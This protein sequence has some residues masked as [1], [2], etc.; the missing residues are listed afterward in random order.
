[1]KQP[2][3][4]PGR[5]V[6]SSEVSLPPFAV[7][8]SSTAHTRTVV[9]PLASCA[10]VKLRW[11]TSPSWV[12]VWGPASSRTVMSPPGVKSGGALTAA[13]M[14]TSPYAIA[15]ASLPQGPGPNR[16]TRK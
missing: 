13:L 15:G 5:K 1:M 14:V 3:A 6:F 16:Q 7:P 11:P 4:F 10:G 2:V 8:P 12:R 9:E